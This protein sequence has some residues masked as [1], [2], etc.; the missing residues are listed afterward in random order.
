LPKLI[1]GQSGFSN[2]EIGF[3]SAIP[4][5]AAAVVMVLVGQSSDR[6]GERR[7]HIAVCAVIG[8]IAL[9]VAAYTSTFVILLAA[10]S[11]A[12]MA[13]NSMYGPFWAMPP[14]MLPSAVSAVSIAFINSLGNLGGFAG[15][16][17]IGFLKTSSGGY[18][19]GLLAVSAVLAVTACVTL[20]LREQ[21][22]KPKEEVATSAV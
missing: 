13:A 18:R 14:A 9:I 10:I 4:Y 2:L 8:M 20:I 7:L 5:I 19:Q 22:R 17:A 15:P 3:L 12:L 11:V 16:Y 6:R 1:R 21:S